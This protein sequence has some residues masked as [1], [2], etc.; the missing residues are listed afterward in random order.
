L[1]EPAAHGL[2][3]VEF[4]ALAYQPSRQSV[5]AEADALEKVPLGH[6]WH[7]CSPVSGL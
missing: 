5:Q 3:A 2:Q 4:W 7:T 6:A 1:E